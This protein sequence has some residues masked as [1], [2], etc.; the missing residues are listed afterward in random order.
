MLGDSVQL[1][2]LQKIT[3]LLGWISNAAVMTKKK[4][5]LNK[6]F[7]P[8]VF[9]GSCKIWQSL[10]FPLYNITEGDGRQASTSTSCKTRRQQVP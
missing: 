7:E 2:C 4:D 8:N 3:L 6:G 9:V 5:L 10:N 1:R